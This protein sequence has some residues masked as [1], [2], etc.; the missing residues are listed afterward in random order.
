MEFVK[1]MGLFILTALAEIIG[2]FLPWLVLRQKKPVAFAE[3][4]C[5]SCNLRMAS[6]APS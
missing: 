4:C 2:C 6:N 5:V 3:R 1:I